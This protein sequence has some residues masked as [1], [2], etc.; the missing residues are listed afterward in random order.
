V[1]DWQVRLLRSTALPSRE[2]ALAGDLLARLG[3]TRE[4]LL[5]VDETRFSAVP[6]G[7]F[8]MGEEGAA[9][10]ELHRNEALDYDYWIAQTPVTVAQFRQFVTAS[11]YRPRD[12][13]SL[14]AP[15]NRPVV[16]VSRH[17]AQAFCGWLTERWR[18]RLPP[19]WCV[20]L[21][22][23]AEWEKAARGGERIP[24]VA[25]VTTVKQG[26]R[27]VPS[28]LME[29]PLPRRIYPWGDEFLA[30]NANTE[31]TVGSAS[32]PGCFEPGRGP[33]GCEDM[34]GNVWEWTRSLWGAD[35]WK[36]DFVSPY[37]PGDLKREALDAG[38]AMYR[39]LRG[40]S[41]DTRRGLARCAFRFR[42]RPVNRLAYLGFR[43][44]LRAAP[45]P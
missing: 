27:S 10:W 9:E 8:W 14:A 28:E 15:E 43:V 32:T 21:P 29:N 25:Q 12:P 3:E 39:V 40:G 6:R 18:E 26:L 13:E 2:R 38:D 4:H 45:V 11:G 33:Y 42:R 37:A 23:E 20:M 31:G 22:S 34:A 16:Q 19:A 5:D 35:F 30:E 24:A 44:V 41:W 7:A 1:R 17:D 36:P